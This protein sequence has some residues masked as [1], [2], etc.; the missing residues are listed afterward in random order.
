MLHRIKLRIFCDYN[1]QSVKDKE[2]AGQT[3][4]RKYYNAVVNRGESYVFDKGK[5]SDWVDF[6]PTFRSYLVDKYP[7]NREE[8]ICV[9]N[10]SIKV[11]AD[12]IERNL[13]AEATKIGT[14]EA[15]STVG[16][17]DED[18]AEQDA[19]VSLAR[20][21]NEISNNASAETADSV[22]KGYISPDDYSSIVKVLID[23]DRAAGLKVLVST[24]E[25][26][27]SDLDEEDL[28]KLLK[29]AKDKIAR[30]ADISLIVIATDNGEY[31]GSLHRTDD[32]IDLASGQSDL[33]A[34]FPE[35]RNPRI[36]PYKTSRHQ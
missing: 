32:P 7:R 9:D 22:K 14:T 35:E 19:L 4:I 18:T 27:A 31:L 10:F 36:I 30:Y 6:I 1:E 15:T 11:Y 24:T 26:T 33:S 28:N 34:G 29:A 3:G 17:S 16:V 8:W 2:A 20:V 5:W 23:Q 21:H 13:S 12:F 25:I